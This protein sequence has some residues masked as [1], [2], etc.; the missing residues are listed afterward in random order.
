MKQ[1]EPLAGEGI[2]PSGFFSMILPKK[3]P[4]GSYTIE[5]VTKVGTVTVPEFIDIENSDVGLPK[6]GK[7]SFTAKVGGKAFKAFPQTLQWAAVTIGDQVLTNW[8]ATQPGGNPRVFMFS[9]QYDPEEGGAA[10]LSGGQLVSVTYSEGF[11]PNTTNYVPGGGFTVN[12]EGVVGTQ[13]IGNFSGTMNKVNGEG[14]ESVQ[15]TD[16]KFVL[17]KAEAQ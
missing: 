11:F 3:L 16:G 7:A 1:W 10:S 13:I 17:N 4:N 8:N 6:P 2:D 5:I 15:V 9:V 14:P 12:I